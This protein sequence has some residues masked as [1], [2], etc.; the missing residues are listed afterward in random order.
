MQGVGFRHGVF[1]KATS[2]GLTG[3]VCNLDDGRVEAHFEGPQSVLDEMLSW[4][5]QGPSLA[6]VRHVETS[7]DDGPGEYDSFEITF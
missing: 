6:H 2:L 3:W 1:I 7:W 5:R 4:Y